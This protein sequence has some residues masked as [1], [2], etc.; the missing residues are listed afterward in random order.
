M[1][2]VYPS[3]VRAWVTLAVLV[4]GVL[5]AYVDRQI[6]SLLVDPIRA[7]LGLDDTRIGI[8]QGPAFALFYAFAALPLGLMIDR[9]N[10]RNI[11]IVGVL[12]WSV[13]TAACGLAV[14][15]W[16]LFAARV[17]V[18][19]GEACLIPGVLS[20]LGDVFSPR[21]KPTA[22][23]VYMVLV[24]VG[25]SL[26]IVA[27]GA[28]IDAIATG[29]HHVG[30]ITTPWRVAFLWVA[31][32]GPL[33]ALS[34]AALREPA[35]SGVTGPASGETLNRDSLRILLW[36][37]PGLA[38]ASVAFQLTLI[39]FPTILVRDY[40]L[41]GGQAGRLLG[42]SVA[43][44]SLG[45]GLAAAFAP[46][47]LKNRLRP[48]LLWAGAGL[49]IGAP[50]LLLARNVSPDTAVLSATLAAA[51]ALLAYCLAPTLIQAVAPNRYWGRTTAVFKLIE[52]IMIAGAAVVVG[53]GS[54][55]LGQGGLAT[56]LILTLGLSLILGAAALL[57]ARGKVASMQEAAA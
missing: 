16:S 37:V 35:R 27:S 10:R 50:L 24:L 34:F 36:L 52:S 4:V 5:L 28:V 39:W 14:D 42:L 43:L 7:D 8:L 9:Y 26:A 23:A 40:G 44:A 29:G 46:R 13:A 25:S 21:R 49:L 30:A 17:G 2:H 6:L 47:L 18:A 31:L 3:S 22:F 55:H 41:S 33:V 51:P 56:V 12:V 53:V 11:L 48:M 54:D 45:V 20:L 38:C 1:S 19:V 32:P 57:R 15:F